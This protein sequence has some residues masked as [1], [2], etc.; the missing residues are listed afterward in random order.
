[1]TSWIA[2]ER[3][4]SRIRVAAVPT[5]EIHGYPAKKAASSMPVAA[6]PKTET[7][8]RAAPRNDEAGGF[9]HSEWCV[10]WFA[11][12]GTMDFLGMTGVRFLPILSGA[13]PRVTRNDRCG[14][15]PVLAGAWF[16][17][18]SGHYGVL[19]PKKVAVEPMLS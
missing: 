8:R 3:P 13:R 17:R 1:M 7:P 6:V 15:S 10:A 12:L 14:G 4:N 16:A 9:V 19:R 18:A 2:L 5:T 11:K